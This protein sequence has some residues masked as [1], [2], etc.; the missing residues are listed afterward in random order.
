VRGFERLGDLA[1]DLQGFIDVKRGE[2]DSSASVGSSTS[3]IASA[4]TPPESSRP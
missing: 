1:G 3:S 4:R 2:L